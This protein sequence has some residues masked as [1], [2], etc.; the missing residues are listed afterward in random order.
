MMKTGCNSNHP[1][2]GA[3]IKVQPIRHTSDI[4]IIKHYL[5]NDPRNLCLFT[6]GINTAYR[7]SELL[8]L[9]IRQVENLK[10]GDV[11]EIKQSK[12]NAYRAT[13]LNGVTVEAVQNWLVHHPCGHKPDAPLFISQRFRHRSLSVSA[14]NQLVKAWCRNIGLRENYGSHTLRKTWGYHQ[15]IKNKASVALLMCAFGH[16]TEAQ[17]LEYLCILSDEI[18][19]LYLELE[20]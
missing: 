2:K 15:R 16:A 3:S 11:L 19:R 7:A 14:V 13:V 5:R 12:N 8:S 18:K 1:K 10:K 20:L 4:D 6:L 9:T 17:T